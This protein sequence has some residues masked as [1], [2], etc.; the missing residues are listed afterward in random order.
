MSQT[1]WLKVG[2][3]CSLLNAQPDNQPP[4]TCRLKIRITAFLA[5]FILLYTNAGNSLH[6]T[7]SYNFCN[8]ERWRRDKYQIILFEQ[9]KMS[10]CEQWVY[11]PISV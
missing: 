5:V 11:T 7:S 8:L 4:G 6:L 3:H 2:L 10:V 1:N 9:E